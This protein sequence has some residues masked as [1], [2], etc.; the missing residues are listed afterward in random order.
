MEHP[1]YSVD[2]L[3]RLLP[4]YTIQQI[5]DYDKFQLQDAIDILNRALSTDIEDDECKE[6][7]KAEKAACVARL[8]KDVVI[9]K[10]TIYS[11]IYKGT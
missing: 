11:N 8:H 5:K 2:D 10:G 3:N 4:D 9:I 6:M 1:A 7:L